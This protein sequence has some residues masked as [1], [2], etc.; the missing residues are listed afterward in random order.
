MSTTPTA[1]ASGGSY[2][3]GIGTSDRESISLL[4]HDLAGE[5]L[6]QVTFGELDE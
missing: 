2:P 5:L 3:T 6:G 1:A 4:G